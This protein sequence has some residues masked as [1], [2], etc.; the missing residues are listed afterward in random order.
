MGDE[1]SRMLGA[2]G[3][4]YT[5]LNQTGPA[6]QAALEPLFRRYARR[7][8]VPAGGL[9]LWNSK[10]IHTGAQR[11]PRLAQAVCLEPVQRRSTHER[12]AKLR[13]A[14][15][16]LPSMHWAS[17]GIQHDCIRLGKGYLTEGQE[18]IAKGGTSH[19][20]M[21][22]PLVGA[23]HPWCAKPDAREKLLK[24]EDVKDL[25]MNVHADE[26]LDEFAELLESCIVDEAKAL[27]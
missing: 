4:H 3:L 26:E 19:S 22:L 9:L 10:T 24:C 2:A 18:V 16:G 12:L 14:A 27:L 15:L 11:G 13:M 21:V 23:I 7:I 6:T 5:E 20:E 1:Y 25:I 8:P 17:Q